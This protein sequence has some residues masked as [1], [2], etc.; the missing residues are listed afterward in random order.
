[1][2]MEDNDIEFSY[3]GEEEALDDDNLN[4]DCEVRCWS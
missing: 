2:T 3:I 4:D 1:M